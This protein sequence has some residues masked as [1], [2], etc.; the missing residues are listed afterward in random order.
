MTPIWL[1]IIPAV[2]TVAIA[3]ISLWNTYLLT[4]VKNSNI[5]IHTA[6]NSNFKSMAEANATMGKRLDDAL[7]RNRHL[8]ET[9]AAEIKPKES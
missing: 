1:A 5:D 9:H 6:V 2:A 4:K 7:D 8:E 3:L